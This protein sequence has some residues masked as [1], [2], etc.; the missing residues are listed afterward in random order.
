M[1]FFGGGG[2]F[3]EYAVPIGKTRSMFFCPIL[4]PITR[5]ALSWLSALIFMGLKLLN[6]RLL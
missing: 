4:D 2:L 6:S 5:F 1:T 3:F